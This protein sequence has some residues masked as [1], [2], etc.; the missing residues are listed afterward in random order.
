MV[1]PVLRVW[2]TERDFI[3]GYS[4][5]TWGPEESRRLFE[6]EEHHWR[7]SMSPEED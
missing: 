5:G 4:A 7:H 1:D 6:K 3:P 2:S